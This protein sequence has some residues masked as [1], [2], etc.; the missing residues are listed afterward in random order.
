MTQGAG[1]RSTPDGLDAEVLFAEA[2]RRRR[3]RRITAAVGVVVLAGAGTAAALSIGGDGSPPVSSHGERRSQPAASS[4]GGGRVWLQGKY[5]T[6][7]FAASPSGA[8]ALAWLHGYVG[9]APTQT[10]WLDTLRP[11]GWQAAAAAPVTA[12]RPQS[13]E[14]FTFLAPTTVA[15][16]GGGQGLW[17]SRDGGDRWRRTLPDWTV[18]SIAGSGATAWLTAQHCDI[19]HTCPTQVLRETIHRGDS[20]T[21]ATQPPLATIAGVVQ[22][23]PGTVVVSGTTDRQPSIVVSTDGGRA[24]QREP[25]PCQP[26]PAT[27]LP[28]AADGVLW[29]ACLADAI[30][31]APGEGTYAVHTST[32]FGRSWTAGAGHLFG[33]G[34]AIVPITANVAWGEVT[35]R[36]GSPTIVHTTD[37]GAHWSRVQMPSR[38][39]NSSVLYATVVA[40]TGARAEQLAQLMSDRGT[41]FVI[42]T[43]TDTGKHWHTITLPIPNN[44]PP[45][46]LIHR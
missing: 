23:S 9:S 42:S 35:L 41:A 45:K 26:Q 37:G 10:A 46:A 31:P 14:Q 1:V 3:R 36:A 6:P 29:V 27:V 34:F 15:G 28:A 44:L 40:Q 2:R 22:P 19:E 5:E 20:V 30:G 8:R 33:A 12:R 38:N 17:L 32:S 18:T 16:F 13:V 21:V 24:W 4:R 25:L 39:G 7:T 43:T 11:N